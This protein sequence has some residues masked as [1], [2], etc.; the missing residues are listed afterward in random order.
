MQRLVLRELLRLE[1]SLGGSETRRPFGLE[2]AVALALSSP[3]VPGAI[4]AGQAGGHAGTAEGRGGL[5]HPA[6]PEQE[7]E[8]VPGG[9]GSLPLRQLGLAALGLLPPTA[10][11]VRS[12]QDPQ[13]PA[14][15]GQGQTGT[16]FSWRYTRH[17]APD[18][19][20]WHTSRG[21][22][23]HNFNF[24]YVIIIKIGSVQLFNI[25]RMDQIRHI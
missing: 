9:R 3:P 21:E 11:C 13:S 19:Q 6:G 2:Q 1:E 4:P 14:V 15:A 20:T 17:G 18:R 12:C 23:Q 22:V 5:L 24:F 25:H 8:A 7:P 16:A 10:L